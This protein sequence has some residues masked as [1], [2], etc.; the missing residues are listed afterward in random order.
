MPVLE[1][2]GACQ[3]LFYELLAYLLFHGSLESESI[4]SHSPF[5]GIMCQG[6]AAPS[7]RIDPPY[8]CFYFI[9]KSDPLVKGWRNILVPQGGGVQAASQQPGAWKGFLCFP[10]ILQ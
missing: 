1:G 6:K 9:F 8:G 7:S 4:W 5:L 2:A 10:S 3:E